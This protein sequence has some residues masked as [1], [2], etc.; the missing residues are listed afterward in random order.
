M[1]YILLQREGLVLLT[2]ESSQH[3]PFSSEAVRNQEIVD[4]NKFEEELSAAFSQFKPSKCVIF[5]GEELVFQQAF[6]LSDSLDQ[7]LVQ[8]KQSFRD[9]IPFASIQLKDRS[10]R[11][12]EQEQYFVVNSSLYESV[13]TVLVSLGWRVTKVLPLQALIN[14][15]V[16]PTI[17]FELLNSLN[18]RSKLTQQLS[19]LNGQKSPFH[20]MMYFGVFTALCICIVIIVYLVLFY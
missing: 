1:V 2:K 18:F 19:F 10:V 5:L 8:E 15:S 4:K 12:N 17:S 6:L 14:V 11:I 20:T 16:T 9:A 13:T 7:A 3:V